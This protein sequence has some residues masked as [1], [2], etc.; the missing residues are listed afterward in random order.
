MSRFDTKPLDQIHG[1]PSCLTPCTIVLFPL[2]SSSA[3]PSL[4]LMVHWKFLATFVCPRLLAFNISLILLYFHPFTPSLYSY[5]NPER[6]NHFSRQGILT[7]IAP[8]RFYS[9]RQY[10]RVLLSSML[11]LSRPAL[12][13]VCSTPP[14][15][16]IHSRS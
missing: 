6:Q 11:L 3:Y 15:I 5:L 7:S 8:L 2:S 12:L 14:E 16:V 10:H 4:Y 13:D 9:V 1:V